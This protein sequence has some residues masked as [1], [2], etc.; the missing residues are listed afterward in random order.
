MT[1]LIH[2]KEKQ[3]KIENIIYT[4]LEP[5]KYLHSSIFSNREIEM[6]IKLRSRMVEVKCNFK[7]KYSNNL[8]CQI[9]GCY[10]EENQEHLLSSCKTIITKLKH[11]G[12]ASTHEDIFSRNLEK[13][14]N[15][16]K[17]YIKLLKIRTEIL[18]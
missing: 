16:A 17:I 4:K 12:P 1:Y 18:K 5:Q 10:F 6:L 7:T 3:S 9:D 14:K 8:V 11:K 2:E 13:Q 15:V